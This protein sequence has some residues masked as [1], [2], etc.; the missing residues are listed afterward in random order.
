MWSI[1]NLTNALN[2]EEY[3][4]YLSKGDDYSGPPLL[5]KE[6]CSLLFINQLGLGADK[7]KQKQINAS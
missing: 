7:R 5:A 6:H 4:D 1:T 2:V 3:L